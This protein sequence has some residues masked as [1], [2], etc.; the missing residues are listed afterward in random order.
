LEAPPI[1]DGF[2]SH[3]GES[4]CDGLRSG[5][6]QVGFQRIPPFAGHM[7]S[8]DFRHFSGS[9]RLRYCAH[10]IYL[11]AAAFGRAAFFLI[12]R[13]IVEAAAHAVTALPQGV[14]LGVETRPACRR[15]SSASAS[16]QVGA[17]MTW[18][19]VIRMQMPSWVRRRL[20][21]LSPW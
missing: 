3:V 10:L 15:R 12:A 16:A 6:V 8:K 19:S 4:I 17:V 9:A 5:G 1:H 20:I 21:M 11:L 18:P 7:L 14:Q 2:A 13:R